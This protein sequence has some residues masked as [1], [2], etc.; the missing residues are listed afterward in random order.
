MNVRLTCL[1]TRSFNADI[2]LLNSIR[3]KNGKPEVYSNVVKRCS[4]SLR[5]IRD[6]LWQF[7]YAAK[8]LNL[9]TLKNEFDFP[10]IHSNFLRDYLFSQAALDLAVEARWLSNRNGF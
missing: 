7:E 8:A 4:I 1:D 2:K 3:S 10:I 9:E 5:F 6:C